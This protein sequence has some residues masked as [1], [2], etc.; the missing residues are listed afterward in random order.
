MKN[1]LINRTKEFAIDCWNFCFKVPKSK[2]IN[3]SF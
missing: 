3:S 2:E 1:D